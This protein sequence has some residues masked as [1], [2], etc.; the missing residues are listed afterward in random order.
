MNLQYKDSGWE[1]G[2]LYTYGSTGL[3]VGNKGVT[4]ALAIK[5][6]GTLDGCLKVNRQ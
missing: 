6:I 1:A 3:S 5:A 4:T 2:S